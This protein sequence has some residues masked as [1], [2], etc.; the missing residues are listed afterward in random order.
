MRAFVP[1]ASVVGYRLAAHCQEIHVLNLR[2][3]LEASLASPL[4]IEAHCRSAM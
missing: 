3:L 4:A 1:A 2:P